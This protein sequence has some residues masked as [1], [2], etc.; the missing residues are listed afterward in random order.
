M[1]WDFWDNDPH[2]FFSPF[3]RISYLQ[4]GRKASPTPGLCKGDNGIA[5]REQV[6]DVFRKGKFD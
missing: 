6:I 1:L 2:C 5:M 4:S 3:E